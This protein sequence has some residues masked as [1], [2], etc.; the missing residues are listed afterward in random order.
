MLGNVAG[1]LCD[2]AKASCALK[3][4]TCTNAA[5]LA[6]T[7]AMRRL[8]VASNEGIVELRPEDSI[9]NFALL[10]NEGSDELDKLIL[11]MIIHKKDQ[12]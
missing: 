6:A 10:G 11:D 8:R 7:L 1:M 3:I 2:G 5:M 4:S 9:D 12:T